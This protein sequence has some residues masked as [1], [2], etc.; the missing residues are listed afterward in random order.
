MANER[1]NL[2]HSAG[3]VRTF[4]QVIE[5]GTGNFQV[6]GGF[7]A[8]TVEIE[9]IENGANPGNGID[10][11]ERVVLVESCT[12]GVSVATDPA[13]NTDTRFRVRMSIFGDPI[14]GTFT[15]TVD[16]VGP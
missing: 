2:Q 15:F 3:R 1:K 9:F 5:S 10:P 11:L 8:G 12:P 13:T 14:D 16:R 6:V 4:D 7:G